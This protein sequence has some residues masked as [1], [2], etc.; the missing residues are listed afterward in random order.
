M[1]TGPSVLT[2]DQL[3]GIKIPLAPVDLLE[4]V[5]AHVNGGAAK[6]A[7]PEAP[8][9]LSEPETVHIAEDKRQLKFDPA[10]RLLTHSADSV[11]VEHYRRL[12]TKILQQHSTKP[13]KTLMVASPHPQEG[14]TL[15]V[16]NL[17][18][19]FGMLADFKVLVVDGDLRRGTIGKLLGGEGLPG[20]SNLI[21]G[22]AS[23]HDVVLKCRDL[24]VSFL[25]RGNSEVA[26]GELLHSTDRL[27]DAFRAV[28]EGFDLVLMDSPPVN[29]IADAH[30]LATNCDAVLLVARA[31]STTR[32]SLEET[33]RDLQ[34]TRIIGT[35]LNGGTRAQLYRRRYQGYY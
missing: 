32:K 24:S 15:T 12:R 19:S 3:S 31:F 18:L 1:K 34:N 16:L 10:A 9:V 2:T 17:A 25:L 26:P 35:V 22:T 28:S 33:I 4:E 8:A 27:R 11:V 14:K 20:L 7:K 5:P 13:F 21:E 23:L 6:L 30:L 29:L